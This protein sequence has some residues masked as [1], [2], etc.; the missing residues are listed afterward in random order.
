MIKKMKVALVASEIFPFAKT[1]GLADVSGALGKYLSKNNVDIRLITPLYSE[2]DMSVSEFY[3][4]NFLQDMELW[5][6]NQKISFS[7]H[8]AKIPD[9]EASVYFVS[10][11]Q[12]YSRKSIYTSDADEHL[13]FAFLSRASI[14]ICQKM[15]WAPDI[16]HCNDWQSALIPL[17][18]KTHYSWN[19]LFKKS[20]TM[21]S[22]HNIGYHY[23]Y[24]AKITN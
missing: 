24:K 1:G 15:N 18:L 20:K 23:R 7:I 3:P 6:G 13:R 16:F 17:Y 2:T 8:K 4:V 14:E 11:P 10:C 5:F 19:K 21:L 9:S 12:L 22:I